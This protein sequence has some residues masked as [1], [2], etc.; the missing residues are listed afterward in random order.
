MYSFQGKKS[1][2]VEFVDG[3]DQLAQH[4]ADGAAADLGSGGRGVAAAAERL[5]HHLH[6]AAADRAGGDH[7]FA[8]RARIEHERGENAGDVQQ[9]IR[10][11]RSDGP[12]DG[13]VDCGN[14]NL[15]PV[16]PR[17]L[18]DLIFEDCRVEIGLEQLLDLDGVR[19][20]AAQE[21]RSL[22]RART[23]A[24][25][26][27]LRVEHDAGEQ[28]LC[29]ERRDVLLVD[30]VLQKLRHQLRC[31]GGEWLMQVQHDLLDIIRRAAVVVDDG[32]TGDGLQQLARLD[33]IGPVRVDDDEQTAWVGL[34]KRVLS[35][36]EN[37]LIVL[38]LPQLGNEAPGHVVLEVDDDVRGLPAL[39]AQAPDAHRRAERVKVSHAVAHDEDLAGLRD[40][41]GQRS[42]HDAGFHARVPR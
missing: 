39:A 2:F 30:C 29:L 24:D 32:N 22:K 37:V 17:G 42:G 34:D 11:L 36:N 38:I 28:R 41:L 6:V 12:R 8:L 35:G 18:N 7:H 14:R 31:R 25:G 9:L 33:L 27:V 5:K 13:R 1:G 23:G 19:A 16:E 40:E 26:E 15:V 4:I 3:G 20:R 10:G 21:G